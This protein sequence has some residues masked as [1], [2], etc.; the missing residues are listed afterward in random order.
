MEDNILE[1]IK[2]MLGINKEDVAFDNEILIHINAIFSTLYQLGVG[3]EG[4]YVIL[5][6]N[7][8]WEDVFKEQDLIDFIKQYTY[9]KVRIIF[10][11]P[12][13]SSILQALNDQMK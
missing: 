13:N 7:E 10:D 8:K 6:G 2:D 1:T 11:P 5:D 9:M 12:T 3:S 4:H